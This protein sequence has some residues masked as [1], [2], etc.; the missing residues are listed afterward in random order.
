MEDLSPLAALRLI[1]PKVPIALKSVLYHSLWLTPNSSKWDLRTRLAVDILRSFMGGKPTPI[2]KQQRLFQIEPG[3]KGPMWIS[4]CTLPPPPE[5]VLDLLTAAIDSMKTGSENYTLPPRLPVEVEWTGHRANA[6]S[7]QPRPDLPEAQ[8]YQKLMSEVTSD[9]TVLY[10]HGG[11]YFLGDPAMHRPSTLKLARLTGGR[12]LSVRYR[13]APQNPFPAALLD[14]FTAYLSLLYPPPSSFHPSVPASKIVFAGDSAGA[15][16]CFALL[17]LLLQINRTASTSQPLP[18]HNTDLALPIP[19]PA[20]VA[21]ISPWLDLTQSMPSI[22]HNAQYD[23][24]PTPLSAEAR[25]S[26]PHDDVWPTDPPRGDLYCDASMLCHPLVS[27]LAASDW[28]GACPVW[29]GVGEE[30]LADESKITASRM[31]NQGVTVQFDMWEAMP[32]CFGLLLE[33]L[34]VPASDKCFERWSEFCRAVVGDQQ[35][36]ETRGRWYVAKSNREVEVKVE[37][38]AP[39]HDEEVERR[40]REAREARWK[41]EEGEAKMMPRL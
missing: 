14:A 37:D 9:V 19:L 1:G 16:L 15:G 34:G 32:H 2:S 13:L 28:T 23:Y 21:S 35:E 41:G 18:F 5:S 38:L 33:R 4:K 24:L 26:F 27:P 22:A 12:C 17:Q 39:V 11:A 25:A 3:I 20:G 30:M 6:R 36:V 31:V 7:D 8:H 29:L 40:M 10:L